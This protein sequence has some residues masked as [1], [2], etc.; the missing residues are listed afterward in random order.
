MTYG[1][2]VGNETKPRATAETIAELHPEIKKLSASE[3]RRGYATRP[4]D[5]RKPRDHRAITAN[6]LIGALGMPILLFLM[7]LLI[8]VSRLVR[9]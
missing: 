1:F 2:Y 7:A 9:H 6:L 5:T 4:I 8:A 3:R